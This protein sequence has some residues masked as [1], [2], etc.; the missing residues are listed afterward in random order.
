MKK[1]D[2]QD[3]GLRVRFLLLEPKGKICT[4]VFK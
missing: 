1:A 4:I 3:L 2:A